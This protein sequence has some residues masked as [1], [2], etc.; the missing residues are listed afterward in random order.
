ML[1]C[2]LESPRLA[3]RGSDA[4]ALHDFLRSAHPLLRGQRVEAHAG[5]C[6][7]DVVDDAI[8]PG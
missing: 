1:A 4:G 3:E 7:A 2:D 5:G 6:V 8:W